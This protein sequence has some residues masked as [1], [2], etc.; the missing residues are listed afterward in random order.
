MLEVLDLAEAAGVNS[1]VSGATWWHMAPR[2]PGG[3]GDYRVEQLDR[4]VDECSRR[5]LRLTLQLTGTPDWVHPGLRRTVPD[6]SDRVWHP[7][8]GEDELEHFAGFVRFVVGRYG[9]AV[10]RY[11]I[12]NE[13]NSVDFWRPEPHPGE[14]A[15]LLRTAYLEA[16]RTDPRVTVASGGLS[17]NDLGFLRQY[18]DAARRYPDAGRHRHF[19]DVLGVHP[20]TDGRSPDWSGPGRIVAGPFGPVDHSFAGLRGMKTVMDENGD[21][22]KGIFVGEF[23]Y[24]DRATEEAWMKPVP[25]RRRALYLKRAYAIAEDLPFVLGLTW[26]AYVPG[27]AVGDEWA[28]LDADLD[29]GPTYVALA[30]ATGG[31]AHRGPRVV[32]PA[33][34]DPATGGRVER[35]TLDGPDDIEAEA[36]E[37]YVD[38]ELLVESASPSLPWDTRNVEDGPHTI[39]VAAYTDD[40]SVWVSEPI[41]LTVLNSPG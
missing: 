30:Q 4:L 8:R 5:G 32:L 22:E 10:G 9:T 6:P 40:G 1:I 25:D 33:P 31:A 18:Y 35:P 7:P 38:G 34:K 13:P 37:L 16:K 29:P 11:E 23:G 39:L 3:D 24:P 2:P 12:W 27:S 41:T 15:T 36:W 17:M 28:I 26:Y 21:A 20:Y 14:Y 19:F